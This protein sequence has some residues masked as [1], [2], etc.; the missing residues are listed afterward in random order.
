MLH[1]G[2]MTRFD[3]RRYPRHRVNLH[4]VV[5]HHAPATAVIDLSEGGAALEW[6]LPDDISVGSKV[7]LRFLL[8][9]DQSLEIEGRIMRIADGRA[10]IEFL[11]E[12]QNLVRQL[13]AEAKS[14]DMD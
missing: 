14:S 4:A 6:N 1:H 7:R 10:G 8:A 12:Q 13:L 11:T 9:A 3:K 5:A 2:D